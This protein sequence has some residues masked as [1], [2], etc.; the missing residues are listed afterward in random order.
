MV[1]KVCSESSNYVFRLGFEPFSRFLAMKFTY[2]CLTVLTF[3]DS[4]GGSLSR[5]RAVF[6]HRVRFLIHSWLVIITPYSHLL[7]GDIAEPGL[8]GITCGLSSKLTFCS[9]LHP[10][11]LRSP[12][13]GMKKVLPHPPPP[14]DRLK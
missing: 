7:N 10:H 11:R 1:L 3:R 9:P 13:A 5:A 2:R 4:A 6:R 14:A 12:S 8:R